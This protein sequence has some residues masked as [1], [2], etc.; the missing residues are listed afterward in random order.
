MYRSDFQCTFYCVPHAGLLPTKARRWL[1][2]D[3]LE[4]KFTD[5][6]KLSNEGQAVLLATKLSLQP[7]NLF[8][9]TTLDS[10]FL[11]QLLH[12]LNRKFESQVGEVA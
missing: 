10:P 8:I 6:C 7:L 3:L 11:P 4:M 5:S 1:S 9:L 2:V 12:Y